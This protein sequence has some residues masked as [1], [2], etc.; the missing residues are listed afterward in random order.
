[1]S[2]GQLLTVPNMRKQIVVTL[3]LAISFS[4]TN[5]TPLQLE[6][7]T[8]I[9]IALTDQGVV[10]GADLLREVSSTSDPGNHRLVPIP[11]APKFRMC[12]TNI[13]CGIAG[14]AHVEFGAPAPNS[15]A[16]KCGHF[17]FDFDN[18]I[19]HIAQEATEQLS[20]SIVA[21]NI[22]KD[23]RLRFAPL[24]CYVRLPE[25]Q[26]LKDGD[27][28]FMF[29]I[30]GYPKD[31]QV[32]EFYAVKIQL[33]ANKESLLFLPPEAQFTA[34][35]GLLP[36]IFFAGHYAHMTA[37]ESGQD[38]E[39]SSFASFLAQ[40]RPQARI[41]ARESSATLQEV[42]AQVA[43]Y[44]DVESEFDEKVGGGSSIMILQKGKLP[45]LLTMPTLVSPKQR[46]R[47]GL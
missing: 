34:G 11:S 24:N 47:S 44:L 36:S 31:G 39:A 37:A 22:W 46:Y 35:S 13:V 33:D 6:R 30:A 20:P 3:A 1:M 16:G 45:I 43:S 15:E 7:G 21:T 10:F 23:V 4:E 9:V 40:R 14:V 5:S 26:F 8:S 32:P 42:V 25:G 17:M 38:P 41:A 19:T 29:L 27:G 18:W 2:A 28:P 12:G